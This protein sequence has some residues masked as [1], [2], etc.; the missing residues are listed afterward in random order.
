MEA[1]VR[2][3]DPELG[4]VSPAARSILAEAI[5]N[6]VAQGRFKAYSAGS[7]PKGSVLPDLPNIVPAAF[8]IPEFAQQ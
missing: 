4:L 8:E 5:L 6:H 1:L 2:W 7:T 3:P